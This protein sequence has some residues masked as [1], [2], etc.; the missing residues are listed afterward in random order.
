MDRA[1]RTTDLQRRARGGAD[2]P[3]ARRKSEGDEDTRQRLLN[4]AGPVFGRL[5]FEGATV[6]EICR[7]AG[8]NVAAIGYHFGDK[9]GL[10][11]EIFRQVSAR[12]E[13]LFPTPRDEDAA[14][15]ER[16]RG[17]VRWLL[18][19]MLS[20]CGEASWEMQLMMREMHSP[21]SAF[22]EMVEE[23]FRPHFDQLVRILSDLAGPDASFDVCRRLAF[24]TVGQC[25]YY[26][27]GRETV[28]KLISS[29][30]LQQQFDIETLAEHISAVILAAC[31]SA[32]VRRIAGTDPPGVERE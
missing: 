10:Y 28:R 27:V 25:L 24:S 26:R 22:D 2:K 9:A 19:R 32:E 31:R 8:V 23:F 7:E 14:A 5:G 13:R 18:S 6:R 17:R 29:D 30:D 16:L 20:D 11:R 15:D 12:R 4:A 3:A 21:T 1:D